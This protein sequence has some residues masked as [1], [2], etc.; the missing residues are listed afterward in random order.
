MSDKR[1]KH[2]EVFLNR[3]IKLLNQLTTLN[4]KVIEKYH[5]KDLPSEKDSDHPEDDSGPRIE[6]ASSSVNFKLCAIFFGYF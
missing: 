3:K 6:E 5:L 1:H 4:L 2:K